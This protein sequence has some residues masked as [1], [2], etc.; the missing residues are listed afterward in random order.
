[1]TSFQ[2]VVQIVCGCADGEID[3]S[4]VQQEI[5]KTNKDFVFLN[6]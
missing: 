2:D 1:M 3:A 4:T 5:K 6:D